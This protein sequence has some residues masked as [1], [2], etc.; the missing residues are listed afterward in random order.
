MNTQQIESGL[1][2]MKTHLELLDSTIEAKKKR[3]SELKQF[4]T[5]DAA[6]NHEIGRLKKDRNAVHSKVTWLAEFFKT[7][8]GGVLPNALN[9]P[10]FQQKDDKQPASVEFIGYQEVAGGEHKAMFNVVFETYQTTLVDSTLVKRGI[11]VPAHPSLRQ[12]QKSRKAAEPV[13]AAEGVEA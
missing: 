12:W 8:N 13:K 6:L 1:A 3:K 10:L 7:I 9:G 11:A 2:E 5:E 4:V